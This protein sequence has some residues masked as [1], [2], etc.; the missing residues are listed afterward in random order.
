MKKTFS[1]IALLTTALAAPG[2]TLPAGYDST[3]APIAPGASNLLSLTGPHAG[4]TVWFDGSDVVFRGSGLQRPLLHFASP[5]FGSFLVQVG[6]NHVLFGESS[7][8]GIWLVSLHGAPPLQPI[9][10]L[11]LNYDA[12][13]LSPTLAVVSAKTGGFGTADNDLYVVDTTNGAT[14]HLAA[15]PG[16]SGPVAIR[17]DLFYATA[18]LTFPTPPGQT[19][20]L[21][22]ARPTLMQAIN[23]QQVLGLANAHVVLTGLDSASDLALDDDDD[24]FFVDWFQS[25]IGEI[26]D[27]SGPSPSAKTFA[28]YAGAS[29]S[30]TGL[31]FLPTTLLGAFEPFGGFHGT[32][33]VHESDFGSVN[34]ARSVVGN[35]ASLTASVANPIPAGAFSLQID[36]GPANGLG[37]VAIALPGGFGLH[38]VSVAGFE[39]PLAWHSGLLQPA[40]THFVSFGANGSANLT[41]ANPGFVPHQGILAQGAFVDAAAAVIGATPH[42]LLVLSQ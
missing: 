18:S 40:N 17:G 31:Q 7:T 15:L 27:V 36:G 20:I 34:R 8:G 38:Q 6:S 21:R 24:L 14:Q 11:A 10:N 25:A 1:L 33:R 9:A 13:M 5:V 30:P 4:A 26:D 3:T 41:L 19:S 42:R 29:S 22:F 39:Q 2:Q 35:R 12:A 28:D 16:A 32:L 37:L 23:T